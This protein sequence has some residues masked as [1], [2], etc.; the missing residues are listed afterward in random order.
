MFDT[1]SE[2]YFSTLRIPLLRSRLLSGYDA[3]SGRFVAVVN[4]TFVRNYFANDDPIGHQFKFNPFDQMKSLRLFAPPRSQYHL[5][6]VDYHDHS[7]PVL[8]KSDTD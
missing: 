1:C 4:Q 6:V 3:D 7:I 2:G 5:W 8:D